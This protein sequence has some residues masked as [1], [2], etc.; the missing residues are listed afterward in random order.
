MQFSLLE[1]T[2]NSTCD[3]MHF[4]DLT[5]LLL[6][7]YLVKVETVKCNITVGYYQRKL[8]QTY[9][10]YYI[11]MDLEIIKFGV[12]CNNACT[13]QRFVTSITGKNA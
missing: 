11:E 6:L 8:H 3:G 10:I 12:L 5:E 1:L 9:H 4:T 2:M 7:H 13:E